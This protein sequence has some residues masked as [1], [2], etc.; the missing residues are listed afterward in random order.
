MRNSVQLAGLNALYRSKKQGNAAGPAVETN[1]QK[2]T[3][4][5]QAEHLNFKP[6]QRSEG[7]VQP[8][9]VIHQKQ[10]SLPKVQKEKTAKAKG[11]KITSF[12]LPSLNLKWM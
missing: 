11:K 7:H 10:T 1:S 9:A 5:P 8:E 3:I 6:V 12:I 2:E 4:L